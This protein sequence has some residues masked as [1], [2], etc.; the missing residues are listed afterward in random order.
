MQVLPHATSMKSSIIT[1]S[2]DSAGGDAGPAC[3]RLWEHCSPSERGPLFAA[4][5]PV[6]PPC[7]EPTDTHQAKSLSQNNSPHVPSQGSFETCAVAKAIVPR[8][9]SSP[10]QKEKGS[11]SAGLLFL[12]HRDS[13]QCVTPQTTTSALRASQSIMGRAGPSRPNRTQNHTTG[14]VPVEWEAFQAPSWLPS[15]QLAQ[16]CTTVLSPGEETV[17]LAAQ[18][19]R[20]TQG[21]PQHETRERGRSGQTWPRHIQPRCCGAGDSAQ[22]L[23]LGPTFSRL[24][25]TG[26]QQ[27]V[28]LCLLLPSSRSGI[29]QIA[30]YLCTSAPWCR[31]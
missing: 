2:G 21:Q 17:W 18:E 25:L 23:T 3:L 8:C 9:P 24:G 1:R 20:R 10:P 30:L 26:R 15:C 6:V 13:G 31:T 11:V 7:A 4:P 28:R 16:R 22:A 27:R 29:L 5:Q 19:G 12:P 14:V